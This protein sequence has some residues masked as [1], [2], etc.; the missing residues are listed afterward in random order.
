MQSECARFRFLK[1]ICMD[2]QMYRRMNEKSERKNVELV[3]ERDRQ[4]PADYHYYCHSEN[5][6]F[7]LGLDVAAISYK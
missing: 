6:V 2:K 3:Q 7:S 5:N 4:K 1:I